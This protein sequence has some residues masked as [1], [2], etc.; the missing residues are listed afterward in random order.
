MKMKKILSVLSAL[1]IYSGTFSQ[2][3]IPLMNIDDPV[4]SFTIVDQFMSHRLFNGQTPEQ[5]PVGE[6]K[7][8]IKHRMGA[9]SGKMDNFFGL[10]QA[11]SHIGFD[12]G[13]ADRISCGIGIGTMQK[14]FD[15]YFKFTLL[16]QKEGTKSFP[17]SLAFYSNTAYSNETQSFSD[18]KQRNWARFSYFHQLL[19]A[20][21]FGKSVSLQVAPFALHR[22]LVE[23]NEDKNTLIGFTAAFALKINFKLSLTGEYSFLLPGQVKSEI[24]GSEVCNTFSVGFEYHSGKRHV[25][26]W[27]ITNAPA[28]NEKIWLAETTTGFIPKNLRIGFNIPTTFTI[29]KKS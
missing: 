10:Y 7:M 17:F 11:T 12:Y 26:Q 1:L 14:M 9:I 20:R 19:L 27:F 23:T 8:L 13:L 21:R 5:V 29:V 24:G 25:F 3:S 2:D 15:G 18:G 4:E 22:N 28:I 6:M 16:Q